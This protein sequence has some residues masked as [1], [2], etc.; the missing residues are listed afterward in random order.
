MRALIEL[1]KDAGASKI[2]VMDHCSIEPGTAKALKA[3]L[4]GTIVQETGVEGLFPDRY[5]A[6]KGTYVT[7]DLPEGKAFKKMGVIRAAVEADVRINMGIAKCHSV[8]RMTLALKHM[9][10]FLEKPA[11]LH[12]NLHKGIADLSTNSKIK[13]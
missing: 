4:L 3:N 9:M 7:I 11:G 1:V 12:T 13:A 10:G 5:L 8:T 6:P 2:I